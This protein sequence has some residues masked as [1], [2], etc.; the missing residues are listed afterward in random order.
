[1]PSDSEKKRFLPYRI[2]CIVA[3]GIAVFFLLNLMVTFL[4]LGFQP[5]ILLVF[6]VVICMLIYS[7]LCIFFGRYVLRN[8]LNLH[9]RVREWI[10]VNSIVTFGGAG[11]MTVVLLVSLLNWKGLTDFA[12]QKHIP[13][14][15]FEYA[16]VF[17]LFASMLFVV[18]VLV[19]WRYLRKFRDHFKSKN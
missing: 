15:Y 5:V 19:T 6:F 3:N 7:N 11:L 17:L 9:V 14:P 12:V 2:L 16:F 8:G 13:L 18:H 10:R 1:M 4:S